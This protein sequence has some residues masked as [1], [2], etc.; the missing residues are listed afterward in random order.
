MK[1]FTLSYPGGLTI[2]RGLTQRTLL[3]Y[4][5]NPPKSDMKT[6][7]VW[8]SLP[9]F[10]DE[11][12]SIGISLGF[13]NGSLRELSC[14]QRDAEL[15]GAGWNDWSRRKEERRAKNTAAWLKKKG[16]DLGQFSWGQ[17]WSSFDEKAGIGYVGVRYS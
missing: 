2:A 13:F 14:A 15:Y 17:V 7:W 4:L 16:Y 9:V 10:H 8:Y 6:G 3:A 5:P 11:G 12:M 1:E